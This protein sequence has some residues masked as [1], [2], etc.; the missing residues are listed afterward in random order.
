MLA[1]LLNEF[2]K[3][4]LKADAPALVMRDRSKD[5]A[6]RDS[7]GTVTTLEAEPP[8]S[9]LSVFSIEDLGEVAKNLQGNFA[10]AEVTYSRTGAVLLRDNNDYRHRDTL[11]L[12]F[13][14]QLVEIQ[15]LEK[16]GKALDQRSLLWVLRTTFKDCLAKAG[17]LIE[18]LRKMR[19]E[20]STT[21]DA[22]VKRGKASYGNSVALAVTG[23]EAV[24]EYV[25]LQVPVFAAYFQSVQDIEFVLDPDEAT[26]TFKF[27]PLPGAI[28]KAIQAAEQELGLAVRAAVPEEI[29]VYFGTTE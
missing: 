16:S 22:E 9:N 18:A 6:V 12:T 28:E 15:N 8:F 10:G 25:T 27:L 13:S 7:D 19:W 23:I 24:P 21:T 14:P 5:Y 26:K 3:L 2:R 29:P 11:H 1:E 20:A 4:S 17:N